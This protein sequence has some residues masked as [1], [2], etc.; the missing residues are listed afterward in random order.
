MQL[1]LDVNVPH[2]NPS[3][4]GR[5]SIYLPRRDGRL[6]WPRQ[7]VIYRDG[8]PARRQSPIKVL[9][10]HLGF[11]KGGFSA[12]NYAFWTK[13]SPQK[14]LPIAKKLRWAI[15]LSLDIPFPLRRR[16]CSWQMCAYVGR[17]CS[18]PGGGQAGAG[19]GASPFSRR[20]VGRASMF[21]RGSR[22]RHMQPPYHSKQLNGHT[23][24]QQQPTTSKSRRET[25]I[26]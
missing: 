24:R 13:L 21:E 15:A 5:Y 6:S 23:P 25:H 18:S 1:P 4:I 11:P 12:P 26:S 7:L 17:Y 8:L 16:H 20:D 2:L 9:T 19:S 22:G 10:R 14:D 3:Q